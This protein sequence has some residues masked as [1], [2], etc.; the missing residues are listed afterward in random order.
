MYTMY[1]NLLAMRT[2][3]SSLP[4]PPPHPPRKQPFHKA[5]PWEIVAVDGTIKLLSSEKSAN[6][7]FIVQKQ[8]SFIGDAELFMGNRF[9][10]NLTERIR[11]LLMCSYF[12]N[13]ENWMSP[14]N[15]F[16]NYS[17]W[18]DST[19]HISQLDRIA[20]ECVIVLHRKDSII[21]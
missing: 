4:N 14:A 13:E 15:S 19:E 21:L 5:K 1:T 11:L 9:T 12:K 7:Y 18:A 20:C 10:L 3:G 2:I 8:T 16:E 17:Q 6:R